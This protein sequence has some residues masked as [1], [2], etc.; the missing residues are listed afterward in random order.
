MRTYILSLLTL[1]CLGCIE[2]VDRPS[3]RPAAEP[4]A[5]SVD[6]TT[7]TGSTDVTTDTSPPPSPC[8]GKV[9][10]DGNPCTDDGCEQ[11]TGKCGYL[12]NT[13]PCDDT[14]LCTV[15]DK[16]QSG[17]CVGQSKDCDDNNP[18][19]VDS[20]VLNGACSNVKILG[21]V[22]GECASNEECKDSNPCT[23]D[24]CTIDGCKYDNNTATCSDNN[25]CTTNDMCSGGLCVGGKAMLCDDNNPCTVDTCHPAKGC[26]YELL[27][28]G[29]ACDDSNTGT[30]NDKCT[31]GVCKGAIKPGCVD[32]QC[33]DSNACT[34]D[35]CNA[36]GTGCLNIPDLDGVTCYPTSA[37]HVWKCQAGVCKSYEK[38]M[39][40]THAECSDSNICTLDLC[41]AGKCKSYPDNGKACSDNNECTAGDTCMSNACKGVEV[42]CNDNNPCTTDYCLSGA[43]KHVTISGCGT[44]PCAGKVCNDNNACTTDSCNSA[45]GACV[46][47]QISGCTSCTKDSDCVDNTTCTA[48]SCVS[49]KCVFTTIPNCGI[50]SN[51]PSF[52]LSVT[53]KANAAAKGVWASVGADKITLGGYCKGLS[54]GSVS[55]PDVVT[56]SE[57]LVSAVPTADELKFEQDVQSLAKCEFQ[58][59]AWKSGSQVAWGAS[60]GP[61]VLGSLSYVWNGYAAVN[62]GVVTNGKGGYNWAPAPGTDTDSDGKQ[63]SVDPDKFDGSK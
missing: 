2:Q 4:D 28:D 32:T 6:T 29:Q 43:C 40:S 54:S 52:K 15:G 60:A 49:G 61:V 46:F 5:G 1:L 14:N 35:K 19:T 44:D 25:A 23:T 8:A 63:D 27:T 22:V 11:A 9:C 50:P 56:W 18:C 41:E 34:I 13:L 26:G 47:T 33:D 51:Q 17:S 59:Y 42:S 55:G 16:C 58:V 12:P 20:C 7:D 45:T 31:G 37:T 38:P 39:C 48:D 30:V 53:W 24:Y 21:C 36:A 57:Q 10:D 62:V 3:K